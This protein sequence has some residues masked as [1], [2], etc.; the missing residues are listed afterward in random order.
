M[1]KESLRRLRAE[2]EDGGAVGL[3]PG[4]IAEQVRRL[5]AYRAAGAVFVGPALL[6]RQIRINTLGDGK[7]LIMP[8]AGLLE[9]FWS[10]APF[11]LP[12][13]ALPQAVTPQ[14]IATRGERLAL[15][16]LAGRQ[17]A[18]LVSDALAVDRNGVMVAEGKGFFD[19]AIAILQQAGALAAPF[20]VVA[21][22]GD[23]L[24]DAVVDDAQPWDVRAD[25]VIHP[26]GVTELAATR[27]VPAIFWEA[28]PARLI[29]RITPLWQLSQ[30]KIF[31]ATE[32]K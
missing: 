17:I 19:L 6:L 15:P 14:G 13:A 18:L 2:A 4:R 27:E 28:L 12:F 5:A 8:A 1:D 11:A 3:S 7:H 16:A 24:G 25:V 23:F 32:K 30:G 31:P 10:L 22:T 29:R 20:T 21:V 26:G 9:G